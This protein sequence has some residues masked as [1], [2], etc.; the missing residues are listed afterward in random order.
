MSEVASVV[1]G[2]DV[3]S[4]DIMG[5]T[6]PLKLM[7]VAS[8]G[9]HLAQLF[10]LSEKWSVDRQS[11]WVTF[12]SAQSESLLDGRRV[13]FVPYVRPRGAF[14]AFR[15]LARISESIGTE[16]F[17]HCVSTGA[18]IAVPAFIFCRQRRIPTT[19]IESFARTTGPSLTGR[20]VSGLR[21][22]HT[23]TQHPSWA[24]KRWTATESVLFGFTSEAKSRQQSYSPLKIFVTLGTVPGFRFDSLIDSVLRATSDEDKIVWQLGGTVRNGLPGA[25]HQMMTIDELLRNS[26]DADVVVTHAGVGTILN[27][28]QHGV[29]PVVVPRRES[30]REHIDDHQVQIADLVSQRNLAQV[31]E[32]HSLSRTDLERAASRRVV[33]SEIE[34]T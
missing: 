29:Y 30:R 17:D 21:L 12:K 8:T 15:A 5:Q 13:L 10:A 9:G 24:S 14:S 26:V 27:L 16:S 20:L 2:P 11:L 28:F 4:N 18:A 31:V 23:R 25:V 3:Q 7:L 22:A 19:Y 1:K 33:R 6:H 32:A 34:L